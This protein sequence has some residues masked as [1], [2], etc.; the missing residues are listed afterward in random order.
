MIAQISP[1]AARIKRCNGNKKVY[2][3]HN[4]NFAHQDQVSVSMIASA[5]CCSTRTQLTELGEL[6]T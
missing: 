2:K 4:V 6:P 1:L 3:I 5:A